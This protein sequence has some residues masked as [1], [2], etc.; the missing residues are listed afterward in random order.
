MQ[1]VTAQNIDCTERETCVQKLDFGV[2][3]IIGVPGDVFGEIGR[4]IK[5][6]AHDKLIITVGY[7]YDSVDYLLSNDL[8]AFIVLCARCYVHE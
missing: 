4:D 3:T 1:Y 8:Q 7:T 5:L 2:C 6:L